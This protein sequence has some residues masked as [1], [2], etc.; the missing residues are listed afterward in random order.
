MDSKQLLTEIINPVLQHLGLYSE[1]AAKLVLGTACQESN[2]RYI[3][4]LGTGPALG[5]YQMEPATHKDIHENY[6][7]YKT[8]LR[9]KVQQLRVPGMSDKDNLIGNLWYS[10]AMCR[11]HYA[12]VKAPLPED[13]VQELAEYWK[14]YYNTYLGKG[15]VQ[16]FIQNYT[17]YG[18]GSIR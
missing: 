10:T 17:K 3:K 16:E 1:V 12:R 8:A 4:Q 6:L 5:L 14:Q 11:V 18:V 13:N 2:L 7:K 15:T 9:T